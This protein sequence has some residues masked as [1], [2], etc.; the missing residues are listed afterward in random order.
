LS[1]SVSAKHSTIASLSEARQAKWAEMNLK[2]KDVNWYY[3]INC[4]LCPGEGS[5]TTFS[6]EGHCRKCVAG[7]SS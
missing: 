5:L 6:H 2:V 1:R 4:C 7:V 3:K